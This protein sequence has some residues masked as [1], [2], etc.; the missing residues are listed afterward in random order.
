MLRLDIRPIIAIVRL[1]RVRV[2]EPAHGVALAVLPSGIELAAVGA[3][4]AEV[5]LVEG[6]GDLD[7]R[8]RLDQKGGLPAS[9]LALTWERGTC[10]LRVSSPPLR[11]RFNLATRVAT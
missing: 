7:I 11:H 4:D 9:A 6:A 5:V 2:H 10:C 3:A 1:E 8:E